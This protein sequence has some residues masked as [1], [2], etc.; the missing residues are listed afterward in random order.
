ME[1]ELQ[2]ATTR[3]E[4]ARTEILVIGVTL[5]P[6]NYFTSDQGDC[7]GF[8]IAPQTTDVAHSAW[9]WNVAFGFKSR[10]PGGVN[11]VFCDGSVRFVSQSIAPDVYRALSTYAGGEVVSDSDS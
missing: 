1:W 10:H 2:P 7:H 3:T 9:N 4:A 6:I 8:D 11:F 5:P